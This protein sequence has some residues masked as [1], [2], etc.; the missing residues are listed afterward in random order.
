MTTLL[1]DLIDYAGLYPPAGLDMR[2]AFRNY[3]AYQSSRHAGALGKFIIGLDR[4]DELRFHAGGELRN[5]KLSVIVSP[6]TDWNCIAGLLNDGVPIESVEMKVQ[7]KSEIEAVSNLPPS[8]FDKYFEIALDLIEPEILKAISFA[9][10]RVKLRMGGVTAEAFPSAPVV[11]RALQSLAPYGIAFKATAGL[12][13]PVRSHHR[14]TYAADSPTGWMHGFVNLMCAAAL[15]H[16]GGKADEA[17]ALLDE[18]D[19]G[20]WRLTSDGIA[21]RSHVWNAD[22]LSKTR[23]KLISFGSCSFEEPIRDLEALGWL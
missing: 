12:H 4:I 7:S 6:G 15:I 1:A 23:K 9:G 11:V 3:L 16:F 21:W 5:L 20:A 22:H 18:R 10:A 14:L 8:S 13:H 17:E 2:T 19:P